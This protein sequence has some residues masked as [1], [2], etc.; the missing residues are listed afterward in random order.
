MLEVRLLGT[1]DIKYKNKPITISSRPAQSLFAYLILSAGTAHRREKLAGMLWPDSLEETAR[2]NLRHALWRVRKALESAASTRFLHADDLT[3]K[4]ESSS[5]YWLDASELER[6]SESASADEL[7][8]I[9]STYQGELLPGFY[10]EWVVSERE[11]LFSIFE[12]HMAQL[13]SRLQEEKHWSDILDWGERWIKLGQKPEPAYRALMTAH[14]AKGDMSKVAATYERCIKSLKEFGLEPSEPTKELYNNLKSGKAIPDVTPVST[15]PFAKETSSNIP[16]PLTS[17]VGRE[18][19]LKKIEELVLSS[20]LLTLTGSGGVG[21][22]RLAIQAANDLL[23][24]FK[25]GVVWVS[26]VG[27]TDENLIPQEIAQ[28]LNVGEL[29]QESAI[30]TLKAYLKSKEALIVLDNCEHLIRG[31]A[32]YTEELLAA[33]PKLKILATSIEA[34]GLFNE[35]TWQVPSLPL[36]RMQELFL[37]EEVQAFASVALFSERAHAAN[38]NFALTEQNSKLVTQ[39]C[40]RLDGIP[41]AIELAAARTKVLSVDEIAARLDNRFSLLTAGSRTA[42]PP[43]QT[44]RAP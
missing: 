3:I 44:L 10:E 20:R 39:I 26:L 5:D 6:L 17:F 7:M 24:K 9:L 35:T 32:L 36:P 4:F 33:C 42:L 21:K 13:L 31:C 25:D 30:E 16:V 23:K 41:L 2:D 29:S 37:L 8:G 19:E 22:T 43:P 28:S 34:L 18:R 11:H 40:T 1:F 14:A 38:L 15:K 12:H 27:L